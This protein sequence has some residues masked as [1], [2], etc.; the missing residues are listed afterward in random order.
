M[1][2]LFNVLHLF[3]CF[4]RLGSHGDSFGVGDGELAWFHAKASDKLEVSGSCFAFEL[5]QLTG[6]SNTS[7]LVLGIATSSVVIFVL[8]FREDVKVHFIQLEARVFDVLKEGF[9]LPFLKMEVSLFVLLWLVSRHDEIMGGRWIARELRN[10]VPRNNKTSRTLLRSRL[11]PFPTIFHK[12]LDKT[13]I[14]W[15]DLNPNMRQ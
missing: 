12:S 8:P 10:S 4:L 5:L 7:I 6:D 14:E 9:D 1:D 13:L 11:P 2:L 15:N 3:I